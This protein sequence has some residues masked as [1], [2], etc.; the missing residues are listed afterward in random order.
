MQWH[1]TEN[2]FIKDWKLFLKITTKTFLRSHLLNKCVQLWACLVSALL[3]LLLRFVNILLYPLPVH[4]D[5]A[6]VVSD[7]QKESSKWQ[8][9]Q[10]FCFV[11][12]VCLWLMVHKNT[13]SSRRPPPTAVAA[14]FPTFWKRYPAH[15]QWIGDKSNMEVDLR[16]FHLFL[17]GLHLYNCTIHY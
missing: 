10:M 11:W 2:I 6:T 8:I 3:Q 1:N 12:K 15:L 16:W 14:T 7:L 9:D 17:Q 13:C 4:L 5:V